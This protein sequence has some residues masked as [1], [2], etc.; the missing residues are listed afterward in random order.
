MRLL[1]RKIRKALVGC[2]IDNYDQSRDNR[3]VK[4]VISNTNSVSFEYLR[5]LAR[6][7]KTSDISFTTH[8]QERC[9]SKGTHKESFGSFNAF[10]VGSRRQRAEL[11]KIKRI[12]TKKAGGAKGKV[13]R[14]R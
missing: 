2:D 3:R 14:V 12:S 13:R 5:D 7:L 4:F 1:E 11:S 10:N 6:L 9:D 8:T